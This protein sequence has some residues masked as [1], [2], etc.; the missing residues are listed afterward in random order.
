MSTDSCSLKGK[1]WQRFDRLGFLFMS[2]GCL[3]INENY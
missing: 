2:E 1:P 3:G